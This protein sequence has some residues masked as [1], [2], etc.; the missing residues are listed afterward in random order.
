MEFK[1]IDKKMDKYLED[2]EKNKNTYFWIW[3]QKTYIDWVNDIH[4]MWDDFKNK[5][6]QICWAS[7]LEKVISCSEYKNKKTVISEAN[8]FFPNKWTPCNKLVEK[9]I[10]IFKDVA[11]WVLMLN[12]QQIIEDQKKTQD[13]KDSS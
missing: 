12:K 6:M 8:K 9:K 3:A 7:L 1:K 4:F 5:Y 13:K 10:S 11:F 2:L